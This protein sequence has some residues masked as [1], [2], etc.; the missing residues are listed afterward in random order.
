MDLYRINGGGLVFDLKVKKVAYRIATRKSEVLTLSLFPRRHAMPPAAT[1]SQ[2][3]DLAS[4]W[5]CV[6]RWNARFE[7]DCSNQM[8][9]TIEAHLI[10]AGIA[11]HQRTCAIRHFQGL[12]RDVT[13]LRSTVML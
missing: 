4:M 5:Y 11:P 8:H 13:H 3:F 12:V 6:E 7:Y 1:F 2:A 10:A 9:V